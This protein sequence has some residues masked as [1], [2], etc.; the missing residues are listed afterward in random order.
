MQV[1]R[2]IGFGSTPNFNNLFKEVS[3]LTDSSGRLKY[4]NYDPSQG[5]PTEEQKILLQEYKPEMPTITFEG[6]EKLHGEN[7]AVCYSNGELWV[8]G[9]NHLR[10][11]K[12]DQ[13]G[14]AH[15]VNETEDEW[16]FIIEELA[17][18]HNVDLTKNTLVVDCEWA[19]GNIQRGNAACSGTD[20]GAYIFDYCRVVNNETD[21]FEYKTTKGIGVPLDTPIYLLS[22][23]DSYNITLDFNKPSECETDLT[24]LAEHIEKNSPIAKYFDKPGN[25][26][27]G[28]YLWAT[29]NGKVLRLKTKGEA[30]GGKPKTKKHQNPLSD[31]EAQKLQELADKVTPVWRITQAITETNATEMKHLGEVMKWVNQDILKE[32][33]PILEKAGIEAKQLTKFVSK[34]VKDYYVDSLKHY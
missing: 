6:S 13:N 23:F 21:E 11:V 12:G 26:G 29:Y 22:T 31:E 8:Q 5:E 14:M 34:I 3:K 15:F 16:F 24:N 30:H 19:G 10:T 25:V 2:H 27:E 1:R 18:L 20:K 17:S 9:R 4:A 28:A 7:M 33:Q 32:E